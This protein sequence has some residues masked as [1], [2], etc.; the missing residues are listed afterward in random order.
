MEVSV[1]NKGRRAA[2]TLVELLVVIA[3]VAVLVGLLIVAVQKVRSAAARTQ[4]VNNLKQIELASHS[5]HDVHGRFPP[6]YSSN[7]GAGVLMYVL[8]YVE[9]QGLFSQLPASLTAGKGGN[10]LSQ[11]GS[12]SPDSPASARISTFLCPSANNWPGVEGTVQTESYQ[13]T[14]AVAAVAATYGWQGTPVTTTQSI[15][16]NQLLQNAVG[17]PNYAS[18]LTSLNSDYANLFTSNPAVPNLYNAE[19]TLATNGDAALPRRPRH[20]HLGGGC[21]RRRQ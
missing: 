3:I 18:I 15:S 21:Q 7:T 10:W 9:Q 4:C 2:F 11:L 1:K 6:G 5:Y 19:V 8:P 20:S 14:P 13:Y 12:L 17:D 16:F